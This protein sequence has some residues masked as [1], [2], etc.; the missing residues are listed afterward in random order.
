M[1]GAVW[2]WA[3][4]ADRKPGQGR[5]LREMLAPLKHWRS[6]QF[7]LYYVVVFGAYVALAAWLPKYYVSV[8]GLSLWSASL[9]TALFIFPASLLRPLGGTLSDRYG[10]RVV[11]HAVLLVMTLAGLALSLPNGDYIVARPGGGEPLYVVPF[12]L[13]VWSM[14][15]LVFVLGVGM[16][17]GKA[18][19]YKYIPDFFPKDVGAVGGLVGMLGALGGFVLPPLFVMML[20]LTGLPQTAFFALFVLTAVSLA[21]FLASSGKAVEAAPAET[22]TALAE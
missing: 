14:T 11:L 16:G 1:A 17:V 10:P 9:L 21:W 12:R 8:Y 7:S 13:D 5:P 18:A 4:A 6:W 22:M 20:D 3:P 15:A 2:L 19:V